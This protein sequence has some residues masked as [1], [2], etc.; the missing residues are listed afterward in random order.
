MRNSTNRSV[1]PVC[2]LWKYQCE[3]FVR[4][5]CAGISNRK[6]SGIYLE[7]AFIFCVMICSRFSHSFEKQILLECQAS[8]RAQLTENTGDPVPKS[9]E[10]SAS[11][12][13]KW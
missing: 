13:S 5:P 12:L 2:W 4:V 3:Q 9:L 6:P 1:N 8:T 7:F 10:H 11:A